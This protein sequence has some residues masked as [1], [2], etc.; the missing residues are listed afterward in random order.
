MSDYPS[1]LDEVFKWMNDASE[2][3]IGDYSSSFPPADIYVCGEKDESL[4]FEFAV[5]GYNPEEIEVNFEGDSLR[6]LHAP[7]GLHGAHKKTTYFKHKIAKRNFDLRYTL[8][9]GKFDTS[10]A[11]ASYSH[12]ILKIEIPRSEESKP[13]KI[14]ID[15]ITD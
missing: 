4:I 2:S 15:L 6:V 7:T 11:K 5:A 12:G 3:N 13:K 10:K 1:V 14:K 9:A 8:S